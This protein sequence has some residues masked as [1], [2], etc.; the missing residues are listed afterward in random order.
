[1]IKSIKN[2][3][4]ES[5][6]TIVELLVVIIVIGI[7]AAITIVSYN[8]ITAKANTVKAVAAAQAVGSAADIY[9]AENSSY[10]TTWAMLTNLTSVKLPS[11]ITFVVGTVAAAPPT[12]GNINLTFSFC[13]TSGVKAYTVGYWNYSDKAYNIFYGGDYGPCGG[14]TNVAS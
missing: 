1:M 6:F 3:K 4:R 13:N 10:P 7:L 11:N 2:I 8:G 9:Y 5:G 12:T 14:W